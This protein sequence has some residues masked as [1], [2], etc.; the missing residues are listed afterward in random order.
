MLQR[1]PCTAKQLAAVLG[2]G[3]RRVSEL[4]RVRTF[5]RPY[6][7]LACVRSYVDFLRQDQGSLKTERTRVTKLKGDLL[8]LEYKQRRGELIPKAV[9]DTVWWDGNRRIRDNVMNVPA[10]LSG[11]MA[12]EASQERCYML[13]ETEL[14]QCL[15]RI[16]DDTYKPELP[17]PSTPQ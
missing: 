6:E 15:E 3:E 4:T 9:I 16:C 10:R 2:I 1:I 7:L 17:N 11:L 13:M 14:R 12:A 5:K 8:D